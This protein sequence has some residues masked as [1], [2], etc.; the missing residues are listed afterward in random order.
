MDLSRKG[1]Q[2]LGRKQAAWTAG[3][4]G[5]ARHQPFVAPPAHLEPLLLLLKLGRPLGRLLLLL[6]WQW[7]ARTSTQDEGLRNGKALST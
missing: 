6:C 1:R 5:A 3:P 4:A 2:R 7:E